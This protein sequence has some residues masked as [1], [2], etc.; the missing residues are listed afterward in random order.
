MIVLERDGALLL[1]R[2]LD[3]AAASGRFAEAWGG[4]G[5]EAPEPA[6]AVVLAA[7]RHDE[8]WREWDDEVRFDADRARPLYFLDVGI[9]DYVRLYAQGIAR[10]S[11][12]DAYAGL[13]VSLHGTGNVCGRWGVQPGVRLS[14]YDAQRWPAVIER[15]VLEQEALG[16]RLRLR[17]LGLSPSVRRGEFERALWWHYELLQ[18]WD[19]LSL[20]LC[21][22]DP[23]AEAEA[24][25]GS[26]RA[27]LD[28]P[29][30]TVFAV[31]SLGR[32]R[33]SLLPWPFAADSLE[34]EIPVRAIPNR[35]YAD[36]EAARAASELAPERP[37]RWQL[38]K[39]VA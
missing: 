16:A 35:R 8:G 2:Q 20:F 30:P 39:E 11:E 25:L 38:T 19:R 15:Y 7:A 10:I 3:H 14:R 21:R 13:L 1:I 26:A 32:A 36:A 5:F 9:E 33:A 4:D 22:T 18:V 37:L 31:R 6:A 29:T 34:L 27:R 23:A 24:D 28:A 17:L 12:L